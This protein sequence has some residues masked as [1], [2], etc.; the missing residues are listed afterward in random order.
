VKAAAI[1]RPLFF[2]R[3]IVQRRLPELNTWRA[4]TDPAGWGPSTPRLFRDA[5]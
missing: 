5:K 2:L 4:G 3:E 1:S